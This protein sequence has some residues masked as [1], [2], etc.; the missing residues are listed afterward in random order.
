M[1]TAEQLAQ[2]QKSRWT[3]VMMV[4]GMV[5]FLVFVVSFYLVVRFLTTD[6]GY[7][8]TQITILVNI[9]LLWFNTVVGMLW[10]KEMYNHYFMA[11]EFFW[12]DFVNLI[13]LITHNAYFIALW[14]N[15]ERQN[16]MILILFAYFTYL[17]N[18]GQWIVRYFRYS[19]K[20]REL[21]KT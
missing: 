8:V 15:W 5:Q 20:R 17:I 11:R 4:G 19:K 10:E 21:A 12:E 3:P 18:F 6:Q 16:I 2:R 1:Y 14:L 7:A 13:A 9:A